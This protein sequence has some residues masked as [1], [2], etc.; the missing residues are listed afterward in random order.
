MAWL[1][2]YRSIRVR[3]EVKPENYC[4]RV[5][6]ACILIWTRIWHRLKAENPD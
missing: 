5:K 6:L 3:Y 4:G 2:K 1:A